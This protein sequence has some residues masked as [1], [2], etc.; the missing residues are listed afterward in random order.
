MNEFW[1]KPKIFG[2][3]AT[4]ITWQ[5]WA[6]VTLYFAVIAVVTVAL[7]DQVSPAWAWIV[8]AAIVIMVTVAASRIMRQKTDGPWR[9]RWGRTNSRNAS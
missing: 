1:F 8:W 7:I 4:P 2:Y 6:F 9:W 5:G 3:G